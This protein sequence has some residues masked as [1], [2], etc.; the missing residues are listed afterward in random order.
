MWLMLS[1]AKFRL[2]FACFLAASAALGQGVQPSENIHFS[3]DRPGISD[4]PTIVPKGNIQLESGI[5]YLQSDNHRSILLPTITL[6]SAVSRKLEFRLTNRILR[7]D[8]VVN[9][10][11]DKFY[12][13]V[14]LDLKY[15]LF[16]E[17]GILPATTLLAGYTFTPPA[18]IR[19]HGPIWGSYALLLMENNLHDKVLFNYNGGVIWNGYEGNLATMYS[20]CFEVELSTRAAVFIEQASFFNIREQDN[21]WLVLGYTHLASR[22]SQIDFS[23]AVDINGGPTDYFVAV[24]YSKRIP[25]RK[26]N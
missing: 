4:Y 13:N 7:I 14:A 23:C 21:Y 3:V 8:S 24:G 25:L 11:E 22:H 5:E 15:A 12:Y 10:Q 18:S 6:R 2:A 17:K 16:Q 26:G 9:N 20:F 1:I 19:L